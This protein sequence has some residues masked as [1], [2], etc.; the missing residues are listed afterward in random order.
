MTSPMSK[1]TIY[2]DPEDEITVIIEKMQA[3]KAK[4]VAL[5][6]PKRAATLQSIV[7][8]KLLKRTA[9]AAKKNIVLITS[10]SNLLPIAGAVGLHVAKS[11]QSK[12]SVPA[13]PRV[14]QNAISVQDESTDTP[15]IVAPPEPQTEVGQLVGHLAAEETIELDNEQDGADATAP[16]V[17]AKSSKKT[18]DKKLKIPNFD[19]FRI[20]LFGGLALLV[21][22]IVGGV[23]A[24]IVLPKA[25]IVINTDT[26]TVTS[27]LM[28]TAKTDVKAADEAQLLVPAVSKQLKKTDTE[29]APATGQRDD[30][31]KAA[32]TVT[33]TNC[34]AEHDEGIT[35]PAGTVLSTSGSGTALAF[36]TN[37]AVTIAQSDFTGSK[38]CKS[39]QFK[40]VSVT[41]QSPG[42][43]YNISAHRTFTTGVTAVTGTDSSAMSGGTTKLTQVVSQQDVDNARQKVVDRMTAAATAELKTQFATDNS[44]ALGDTFAAGTPLVTSTPNVNDAGSGVTVNVTVTYTELGVKQ[45]DLKKVLEADIK[46]HI[47]VS[48]QVIQDNGLSKATTQIVDK[49][50]TQAKFELKSLAVAGPQLDGA[51]IIKQIA[52]KKKG[53]TQTIIQSRPGIK[54]VTI[55]YSPFWVY[56]TPK[57]TK[58]ITVTFDQNNAHK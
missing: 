37:E 50:P 22:L 6:L 52:G 14:N 58:H 31:T 54:D 44:Q 29:K 24:F 34:N 36:V 7:N 53:E 10:E 20:L 23:F 2:I 47:D 1:D 32:G 4:V 55:S 15:D 12:P 56:Q 26:T 38:A 41:A 45:D 9:E 57:N 16:V 21:L 40:N 19:R 28:I 13:A 33:I 35:L 30:G 11:L 49:S 17:L 8:L 27:D 51:G 18:R 46:K 5:V 42:G 43:Q 39:N 48:K 3:S 25:K